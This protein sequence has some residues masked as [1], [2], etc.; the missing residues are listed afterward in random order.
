MAKNRAR[1]L[2]VPEAYYPTKLSEVYVSKQKK[3]VRGY[4]VQVKFLIGGK[5]IKTPKPVFGNLVSK[6]WWGD[7]VDGYSR[8]RYTYVFPWPHVIPA[9]C[10][11][12][13]MKFRE[14]KDDIWHW[15]TIGNMRWYEN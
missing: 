7:R 3:H 9:W 4:V 14:A 15:V 10:F 13:K 1:V 5:E 2:W 12:K 11:Y 6:D 8:Y